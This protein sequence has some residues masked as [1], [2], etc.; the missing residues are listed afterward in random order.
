[1]IQEILWSVVNFK[2]CEWFVF[3]WKEMKGWFH[4][5]E[6]CV[7]GSVWRT[8][9]CRMGWVI[10]SLDH[11]AFTFAKFNNWK[12]SEYA[13]IIL[14][15]AVDKK[16]TANFQKYQRKKISSIKQ[17]IN[18]RK[19]EQKTPLFFGDEGFQTWSQNIRIS[20]L[21]KYCCFFLLVNG[22]V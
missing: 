12:H 18:K 22:F 8:E 11:T 7:N 15:K 6:S 13:D 5:A 2:N 21:F 17:N 4:K 10:N 19:T 3:L 16:T 9:L 20:F 1:M 14:Y